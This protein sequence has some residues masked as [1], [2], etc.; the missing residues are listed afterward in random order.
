MFELD[1]YYY[2]RAQEAVVHQ[3]FGWTMLEVFDQNQRLL[4]G[5]Y[6]L[7]FYSTADPSDALLHVRL[8]NP[9][10]ASENEALSRNKD[11]TLLQIDYDIPEIHKEAYADLV[12]NKELLEHQ[13]QQRA[14]NQHEHNSDSGPNIEAV[15]LPLSSAFQNRSSMLSTPIR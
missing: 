7:P 6:R 9:N 11:P 10:D 8:T 14:L 13:R 15:N 3:F 2:S 4:K 1:C 5:K 12:R